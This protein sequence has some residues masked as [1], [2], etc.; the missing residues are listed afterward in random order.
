MRAI[1]TIAF[2]EWRTL[3][4]SPLAWTLL[5]V[6]FAISAYLFNSMIHYYN[7]LQMQIRMSGYGGDQIQELPFTEVAISPM[8]G[9]T[10]IIL[11]LIM[12][13]ITMR[14]I[15]DEKRRDTWPALACSPLSPMQIILGKYL[16][17]LLFLLVTV[18]LLSLL[19]LSIMPYASPDMGQVISGFL[20]LFLLAASFGAVGLAASSSTDNP[21]V[22]SV[23]T[24]G[25]LLGLWIISWMG[26][27]ISG[28]AGAIFSYLS[29]IDH[30]QPFLSGVISSTD[31]FYFILL[32]VAGLLFARQRLMA[33]RIN[34]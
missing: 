1:F 29:L 18:L 3:F 16:G 11:L 4:Q 25:I 2:R 28:S 14:L 23:S 15:A 8:L 34:G 13:M 27:E 20:G 22:A 7:Q 33:E 32:S 5:A 26:G 6:L 10:A 17:L 31:L 30:Y 12:P 9:N 24:F 19:P 21:I